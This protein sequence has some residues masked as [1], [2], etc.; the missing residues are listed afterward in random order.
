MASEKALKDMAE[1]LLGGAKML[2]YHCDSCKSPL[3]EKEGKI[4]CPVC[5]DLEKKKEARREEKKPK[6]DEG[7]RR[8][9][10]KKREELVKKLEKEEKP[11]EISALLDAISKIDEMYTEEKNAS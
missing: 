7:L 9:L 4:I 10:Q 8:T 2:Q 3:F 11:G 5:G 1:L 6:I